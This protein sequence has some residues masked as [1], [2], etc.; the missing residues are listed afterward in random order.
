M[1][2]VLSFTGPEGPQRFFFAYAVYKLGVGHNK[3]R[4]REDVLNEAALD[5]QFEAIAAASY[6]SALEAGTVPAFVR[7]DM[8]ELNRSRLAANQQAEPIDTLRI[9]DGQPALFLASDGPESVMHLDPARELKTFLAAI[10]HAVP[11]TSPRDTRRVRDLLQFLESA[12][13]AK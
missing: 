1:T 13:T 2:K 12:P 6:T 5:D 8:D 9:Q 3:Q 10:D 7:A 11:F 4:T